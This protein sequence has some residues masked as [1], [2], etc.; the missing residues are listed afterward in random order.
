MNEQILTEN[1][2]L[3]I[4]S[5]YKL[6]FSR[7]SRTSE[8]S[9]KVPVRHHHHHHLKQFLHYSAVLL[10]DLNFLAEKNDLSRTCKVVKKEF[11][12]R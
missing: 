5:A 1:A 3:N 7:E 6:P 4:F 10:V 9:E 12:K 2:F 8:N 11:L